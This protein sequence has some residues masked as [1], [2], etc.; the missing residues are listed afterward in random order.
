MVE[1]L[2]ARAEHL[3]IIALKKQHYIQL[4]MMIAPA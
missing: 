3:A 1:V 4:M 2:S